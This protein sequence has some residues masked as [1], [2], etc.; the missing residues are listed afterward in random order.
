M[1]ES[2]SANANKCISGNMGA[3]VA[4]AGTRLFDAT[5]ADGRFEIPNVPKGSH[6]LFVFALRGGTVHRYV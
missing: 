2:V 6:R 1:N 3:I 5:D 4:V